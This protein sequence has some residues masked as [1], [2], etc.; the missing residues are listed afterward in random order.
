MIVN[1]VVVA[2]IP[3]ASATTAASVNVRCFAS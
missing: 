3:I 2:D 1:M